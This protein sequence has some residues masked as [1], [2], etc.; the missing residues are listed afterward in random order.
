MDGNAGELWRP[1]HIRDHYH[2]STQ[3]LWWVVG[4]KLLE[5]DQQQGL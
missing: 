5:L 3:H 1:G 4:D 2:H